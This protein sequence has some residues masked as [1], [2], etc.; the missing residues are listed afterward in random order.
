[1]HAASEY[2]DL[3]GP[4]AWTAYQWETY[5]PASRVDL[6]A[7]ALAVEGR[8]FFV[9][10][11]PLARNALDELTAENLPVGIVVTNGN[12]ARAAEAF[13]RRFNV[14]LC[15]TEA[16][17]TESGLEPDVT[18]P[19]E[20][21]PVFGGVFEAIPVPGGAVGEVALYRPDDGGLLIVGDAVINLPSFPLGL[22]PAKYCSS[23]NHLRRSV[24]RL[25]ERPFS[26]MLF[27]HGEPL[28]SRAHE[29]LAALLAGEEVTR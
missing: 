3:T 21:G 5:D 23:H 25:L 29:R 20:G 27:A 22:L 7:S 10:P 17:R 2:A 19:G 12:H 14:P 6:S 13:R 1:M 28:M 9:D 24:T 16:A 4:G 15:L 11:I 18:I 8:L 26:R